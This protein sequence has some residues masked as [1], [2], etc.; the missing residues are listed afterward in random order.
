MARVLLDTVRWNEAVLAL[1]NSLN[2]KQGVCLS[3]ASSKLMLDIQVEYL[4]LTA[5]SW[6]MLPVAAAAAAAADAAVLHRPT[7]LP[8][9]CRCVRERRWTDGVGSV[10]VLARAAIVIQLWKKSVEWTFR[11]TESREGDEERR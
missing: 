1:H 7:E 11:K 9:D 10:F 4:V 2:V 3:L 5:Y 6:K 8:G